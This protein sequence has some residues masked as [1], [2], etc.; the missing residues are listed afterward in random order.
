[1]QAPKLPKEDPKVKALREQELARSEADRVESIQEQLKTETR[2]RN[3][4]FG[5]RSLLGALGF[6]GRRSLLG[7]G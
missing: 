5:M 6:G 2:M 4:L 3:P 7:S 1:M